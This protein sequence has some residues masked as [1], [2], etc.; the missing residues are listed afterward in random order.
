MAEDKDEQIGWVSLQKDVKDPV[1]QDREEVGDLIL[2]N[3]TLDALISG[4]TADIQT[5]KE[6][7]TGKWT[8]QDIVRFT[9]QLNVMRDKKVRNLSAINKI[10]KK[11]KR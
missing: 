2:Q 3:Q 7:K 6:D 5:F 10:V 4:L 11:Q 8:P 1:Q 9:I